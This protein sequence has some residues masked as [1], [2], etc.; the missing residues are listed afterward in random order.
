MIIIS[1]DRHF[2]NQVCTHMADLDYGELQDLS[3]ATTT[4]T[5]SRR[6]RRATAR[7][8]VQREGQGPDRRPAG[9]RAA[10]SRPTR[11]R[12]ARPPRA[13]KQIEK[14]K[15]DEVKPSVAAEPVHPLRAGRRSCIA[16]PSTVEKLQSSIRASTRSAVQATS[17]SPS[18]PASASRSS[19]P[20][21]SARPR[22]CAAWPASCTPDT[23]KVKWAENAELGYMPQDPQ[24]EFAGE[25]RPVRLD[26]RA[27]G[28]AD[29]DQIVRATL[30]PPAVLRRRDQEVG[31]GALRRREGPHDVRQ[32]HAHAPER[33]AH[34]RADQPPGHG[35]DRVAEHRRSRNIPAR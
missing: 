7:R 20:T 34:G 18:R 29:D 31:E 2:L 22:C 17:A 15:I 5:C 11:R 33:A 1:H 21:A 16:R 10:A 12:R 35:I 23:G 24:A 30:G 32:A 4:T 19:A 27:R 6:R 3:R 9:V 13:R 28:K 26:D 8:S 25:G 14:I